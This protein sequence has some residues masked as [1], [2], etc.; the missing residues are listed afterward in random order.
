MIF[1]EGADLAPCL[2][3]TFNSFVCDFICRCKLGGTSLTPFVVKQL[4]IPTRETFVSPA[5]FDRASSV[6]Q[7]INLRVVELVYTAV[8]MRECA[9]DFGP[10]TEPFAWDPARRFELRCELDAAFFHLYGLAEEDVDYVMETF[11]IVKRR[12]EAK[13][14]HYRT[15]AMILDVYLKMADAIATGVQYETIL[16][17]PP[18][19]PRV[20]HS[21]R[22][23]ST[24]A[25]A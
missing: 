14:G 21:S 19:D 8:D 6:D 22:E 25:P 23:Q 24:V 7:W 4:P 11:P 10:P 17:P 9:S 12:D 13:Y 18:A 5:P 2:L 15:K 1:E 16:D 3:A 20:A